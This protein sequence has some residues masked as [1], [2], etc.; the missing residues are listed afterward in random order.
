[1]M[2]RQH[3]EGKSLDQLLEALVGPAEVGSGV[4]EQ[5]KAAISLR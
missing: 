3:I 5:I 1:M 2:G 4:H